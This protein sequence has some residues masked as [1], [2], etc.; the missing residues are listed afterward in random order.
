[1]EQDYR[2]FARD[3]LETR[4]E[5]GYPP[6][7]RLANVLFSGTDEKQTAS[8]AGAASE[9]LRKLLASRRTSVVMVGPAPCPLERI[10]SRWRWHALLKSTSAADLTRVLRYFAEHYKPP[11]RGGLRVVLDR[12]P[13]SLL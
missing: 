6:F 10:K 3:E 2:S 4:A 7:I 8:L 13:V 9:W 12:D 1:M 11:D 5:P